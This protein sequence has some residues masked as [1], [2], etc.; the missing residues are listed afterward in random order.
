MTGGGRHSGGLTASRPSVVAARRRRQ[1]SRSSSTSRFLGP[2]CTSGTPQV[3][4]NDCR[5]GGRP[6]PF[7]GSVLRRR[8]QGVPL[9]GTT[10]L[11]SGPAPASRPRT[12][13]RP[14]SGGLRGYPSSVSASAQPDDLGACQ[15]AS[16]SAPV[17][18]VEKFST[19]QTGCTFG[20][21]SQ[22]WLPELAD[23]ED[24][25]LP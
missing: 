10:A 17:S 21:A 15:G 9:F 18:G 24:E 4:P 22:H 13:R 11:A 6:Q 19:A 20:C 12:P 5:I 3:W 7:R 16:K 8:D 14:E 2:D 25:A 1:S 23:N